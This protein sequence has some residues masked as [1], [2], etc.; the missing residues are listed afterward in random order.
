MTNWFYTRGGKQQGPISK[1]QLINLIK[2]GELQQTDLVWHADMANWAPA[3]SMTELEAA[4]TQ[5]NHVAP[6]AAVLAPTR[7]LDI[8][9]HIKVGFASVFASPVHCLI[10][11]L[12][13][14]AVVGAAYAIPYLLLQFDQ[15][16]HLPPMV[17]KQ[18]GTVQFA[19][20]PSLSWVSISINQLL[21]IALGLCLARYW[22]NRADQKPISVAECLAESRH[23]L[24]SLIASFIYLVLVLLGLLLLIIPGIYIGIRLCLYN[25]VIVDQ[26]LGPIAALKYSASITKG[27]TLSILM[28]SILS[29]FVIIAGILAFLVGIFIAVP[30]VSIALCSAY[31]FMQQQYASRLISEES[32]PI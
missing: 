3:A 10:S 15:L 4:F 21:N 32:T 26:K 23:L 8:V 7:H 20:S 27:N 14:I 17:P 19:D 2:T 1:E 25:Q 9:E 11:V 22:L 28:L 29:F 18:N 12:I 16:L 31:R 13:T 30:V 6:T 24:T 5:T